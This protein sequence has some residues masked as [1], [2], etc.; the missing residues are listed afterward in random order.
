MYQK[1]LFRKL[2]KNLDAIERS[3]ETMA[4]LSAILKSLVDDFKDDLGL[5]GGRLYV[6]ED[7][8]FV[9]QMEYPHEARSMVGF[10]IP[11]S[12]EPVQELLNEG[13]VLYDLDDPA[14]DSS[15]EEA[16]GVKT[17]AAVRV[18]LAQKRIMAFSLKDSSDRHNVV[19]MLNT[20]GHLIN[21]KLRKDRLDDNVAKVQAIQG[22][23]LPA[24]P[25]D[26][27]GFSLWAATSPAEEVGGD[28]YDFLPVSKRLLGVAIADAAG[29]GLP[30]ALQAR[31]AIIGLR[32]GVEDRQRI[33]S[34]IE[35]LN[36]VISRAALASRFISLFYGEIEPNGSMVYC[37][38]GHNPPL[39]YRDREFTELRQ[40]GLVLGPDP[41]AQYER[42][43]AVLDR[44]SIL[45]MFTD[46]IVE[47]ADGADEMFEI[48]RL[49]EVITSRSWK[50]AR[51]LVEAIF[52]AVRGFSDEDPPLDDQTVV[53]VIRR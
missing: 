43:H 42:S 26:F 5:V 2:E 32:M 35:K 16:L 45:V 33:T 13:F 9:L 19:F 23:L 53:A 46:G 29:H 11:D 44:G 8:H 28:L 21:L 25:P 31:D 51:R 47:A 52:S 36:R 1:S 20:I 12:Y 49:K 6:R 17:F 4:T 39:L 14:V 27:E 34:T 30:A 41:T 10:K 24:A 22:S 38:A 37:N 50:S 7:D 48:D 3:A 40:G 18:G 15:I